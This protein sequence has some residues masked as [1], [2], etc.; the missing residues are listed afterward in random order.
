MTISYSSL[1]VVC[2]Q[3]SNIHIFLLCRLCYGFILYQL[4]CYA[5]FLTSDILLF[6]L[7]RLPWRSY[8]SG[9]FLLPSVATCLMEGKYYC[10][11]SKF[12]T[13]VS[14]M[15]GLK[16]IQF[17][18]LLCRCTYHFGKN[19]PAMKIGELMSWLWKTPGRDKWVAIDC[20]NC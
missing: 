18:H 5:F 11:F 13:S 15:G 8:E 6:Q 16:L 9:K 7:F 20:L 14:W 3:F 17:L 4:Q 1:D 10:S 2:I 12:V 19:C